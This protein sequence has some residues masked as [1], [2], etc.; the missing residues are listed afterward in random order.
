MTPRIVA[1]LAVGVALAITAGARPL[2]TPGAASLALPAPLTA[3]FALV[4][5]MGRRAGGGGGCSG[6]RGGSRAVAT[7]H[8]PADPARRRL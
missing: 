3:E 2:D 7:T 6:G 5:V 4:R 1:L 8:A